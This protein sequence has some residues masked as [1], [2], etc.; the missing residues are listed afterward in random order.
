MPRLQ[1]AGYAIMRDY[2]IK[3]SERVV[4]TLERGC[5]RDFGAVEYRRG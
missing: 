5:D 1:G 4:R 3:V 2:A